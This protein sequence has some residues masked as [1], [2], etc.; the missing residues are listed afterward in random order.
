MYVTLQSSPNIQGKA[1]LVVHIGAVSVTNDKHRHTHS[2]KE[3][4]AIESGLDC[5][6]SENYYVMG[7]WLPLVE[8]EWTAEEYTS[9]V[10]VDKLYEMS[11]TFLTDTSDSMHNSIVIVFYYVDF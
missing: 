6:S 11:P 2:A 10:E 9:S 4:M 3:N 7:W 8:N 1:M 5:I